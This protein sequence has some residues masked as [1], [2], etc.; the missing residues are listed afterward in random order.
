MKYQKVPYVVSIIQNNNHI[1]AGTII[2]KNWIITSAHC[3]ERQIN[4]QIQAGLVNLMN[5]GKHLQKRRVEEVFIH[6]LYVDRNVSMQYDVALLLLETKLN[7]NIAVESVGILT[8][9]QLESLIEHQE[10]ALISS[11]GCNE[12]ADAA[13]S[14]TLFSGNVDL[15]SNEE[16]AKLLP[17]NNEVISGVQLC[18]STENSTMFT[19]YLDSGGPLVIMNKLGGFIIHGK[20]NRNENQP[21]LSSVHASVPSIRSFIGSYIPHLLPDDDPLARDM[22]TTDDFIE[23][24]LVFQSVHSPQGNKL[25]RISFNFRYPRRWKAGNSLEDTCRSDYDESLDNHEAWILSTKVIKSDKQ[26]RGYNSFFPN[27]KFDIS[28]SVPRSVESN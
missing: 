2:E 27:F 9:S 3:V 12:S 5:P 10:P 11:W 15:L 14:N 20:Q 19:G 26:R 28:A 21:S 22:I 7:F 23:I 25:F 1:C 8:P 13:V 4:L 6:P 18:S 17:T 24:D 16:C